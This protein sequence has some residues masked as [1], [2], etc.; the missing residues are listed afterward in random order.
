MNLWCG[1]F[2]KDSNISE[3]TLFKEFKKS[4]LSFLLII[5][6]LTNDVKK[7][8]DINAHLAIFANG[9]V[10]KLLQILIKW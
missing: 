6:W 5:F 7:F 8:T 3:V 10:P 2:F 1:S 4:S 9:R